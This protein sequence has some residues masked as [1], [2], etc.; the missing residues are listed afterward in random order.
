LLLKD[1]KLLTRFEFQEGIIIMGFIR[2]VGKMVDAVGTMAVVTTEIVNLIWEWIKETVPKVIKFFERII[3]LTI[4]IIK[5]WFIKQNVDQTEVLFTLTEELR[6][7]EYTVIQGVFSKVQNDVTKYRQVNATQIV[8]VALKETK[9][10]LI[11]NLE[12]N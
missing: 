9:D 6:N 11:Y 8:D 1:E 2:G 3:Q 5:S 10:V 7:G 12:G 4:D